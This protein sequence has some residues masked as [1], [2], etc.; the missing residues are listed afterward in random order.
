MLRSGI[1]VPVRWRGIEVQT[2]DVPTQRHSH[3]SNPGPSEELLSLQSRVFTSP[4]SPQPRLAPSSPNLL[5]EDGPCSIVPTRSDRPSQVGAFHPGALPSPSCVPTPNP[6][7]SV[8][9]GEEK[10][11]PWTG[12]S[13]RGRRASGHWG[14]P[15]G[16]GLDTGSCLPGDSPALQALPLPFTLPAG[17]ASSPVSTGSGP[18]AR[19]HYNSKPQLIGQ[20]ALVQ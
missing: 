20:S 10:G 1:G 15:R 3:S 8:A 4:V 2:R 16:L 13:A 14:G 9:W 7:Q 11:N 12:L 18:V 5:Q 17:G 19:T 6:S